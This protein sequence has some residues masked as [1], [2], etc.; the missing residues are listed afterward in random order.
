MFPIFSQSPRGAIAA[1]ALVGLCD[2]LLGAFT[3]VSA[4]M[5]I[6]YLHS[7]KSAPVNNHGGAAVVDVNGDGSPDLI[8][9]RYNLAPLLYI[10][11]GSGG[12]SEET[13]ARGLAPAVDAA[14]FGA[15]DFDND[16]DQ[17][18]FMSVHN[19]S[20]FYLFMNDGTGN[21]IED[22]SNRGA[23]LPVTEQAHKAHSIGLIDYDLD[24]YLDI[25]ISEWGVG[26]TGEQAFHS[27]L[28]RNRGLE[29]PGHFELRTEQAGLLQPLATTTQHGFS[30]GWADFDS[31]SWPDLALV[32]DYK[33][34]QMYW[35]DGDGTFTSSTEAS[36]VGFDENGMGV[37]VADYDNDGLLDFFV[38]SIYDEFSNEL[39]GTHAG[40]KLYRNMG[41]RNFQEVSVPAG[42]SRTGWGW[43]T[44]FFEYDND[45]DF[46]LIATNGMPIAEGS[47]RNTTPY[48]DAAQDPTT[49]FLNQDDGTFSDATHFSGISD[50]RYG[51]ALL[52]LDWDSD[53]D[54]DLV[55]V[56]SH[57]DPV[58]YESDASSG[59]NDWIRF[60][61][62]GTFSNRDAIGTS[63][64]VTEGGVTRHLYFN[65]SNA[66][67]GQREAALHFGLGDSDGVV[68]S[69]EIKWPTG[70]VQTLSDVPSNQTMH[71]RE[72]DDIPT[73]PIF[74]RQP[75]SVAS[76]S[77]GDPLELAVEAIGSPQPIYIWEKDGVALDGQNSSR[78]HLKR[79][80][81]FD[82]GVYR[83]KAVSA[84]GVTY[85][86]EV[87]VDL[88]ID[89]AT[90]SV[91]RW[92]NEFLLEAIRKDFPDPTKHSRNLYHV[93]A[94][95][96]DA[97][98]AYESDGWARAKP[99]FHRETVELIASES[100]R[101][102]AQREAISHAA[103]TVLR[104]RY[105]ESPGEERSQAG[106]VWLMEQFGFDPD[107]RS[108]EGPSPAAVG[109]RIGL[110]V[111]RINY[112]DGSN[113]LNQYADTS[114][115]ATVNEPLVLELSGTEMRDVNRWQ[116]LAF[117]FAIS[118]NG[119]PLGALVQTFL[120]VNWREVSSFAM[121]KPSHNTIAFDPGPPP[122][123]GGETH[124]AF[125]DA[126]IE[127]IRYSSFLDPND[128]TVID[129]SPGARLNN[130]LASNAGTGRNQNPVTGVAY[131]ANW[132]KRADYGRILAE[133]WADGP[134][135]ET[136]PGHWNSL[137]NEITDHPSF[138]RKYMGQGDELEPLEWDVRAYLALNGGMH[139]AAV[140][141]WTLKAQYDYSRPISMI[142]FLASLGQASDSQLPSFDEHGIKLV[143]GLVEVVTEESS[144]SGERHENFADNVGEIV[145][146]AWSGEPADA[147]TQAG[148]VDWI[149]A[150]DWFPYQRG[151]F[152]T[153]AFAAYVS[154]HST[155]SRAGAE[156]LTL[157]TGS[158]FFP[159]GLGEFH[160]PEGKFLEFEYG[161][162]HDVTLQWA[163]YYDAADQ[164]GVSRLYGGIHVA[165]DD[166]IGRTL[167]ARVGVEAFLRAHYQG[168]G[169]GRSAGILDKL[170][171]RTPLARFG[172]AVLARFDSKQGP[173][174]IKYTEDA[175]GNGQCLYIQLPDA[176]GVDDGVLLSGVGSLG[177]GR[178][179]ASLAEGE[180]FAVE[181]EV[182]A[183]E[184]VLTVGR[185]VRKSNDNL[186]T[187]ILLFQVL[188]SGVLKEIARNDYWKRGDTASQTEALI[189]RGADE[190]DLAEQDAALSAPLAEGRYRVVLKAMEGTGLVELSISGQGWEVAE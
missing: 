104:H 153:P 107:D 165:A 146:Y 3:D 16:G 71:L 10:N 182:A 14:A 17:D 23:D 151:S 62:E 51:K 27:A 88:Q 93:S 89:V 145:L 171:F 118:Q 20:R 76:Y 137:H 47:D 18:L 85:S 166:F 52:V 13:A 186:D 169:E 66:Y 4:T 99:M 46:D 21:F 94:A 106:F 164:A 38:T 97:F 78:L 19:G 144:A 31:D 39:N 121:K 67:I 175:A 115:Y 75:V 119:I 155:F 9:A 8:F 5:G 105:L 95:M 42:V 130:P 86:E 34:S 143:P 158:P 185:P 84:G 69:V 73:P 79:I 125:V 136:P 6:S 148:G 1:I 113:E 184:L 54:E 82:T 135:S 183:M 53:G 22:A 128:E 65:P 170:S 141:A 173:L 123:W 50:N 156:V 187:Q 60:T 15:A 70:L 116:P 140:A 32:A 109:N 163:T 111:L 188:E 87:A 139:D 101:L 112:E 150:A 58:F 181:F 108:T 77:F 11:D 29:L 129:I 159:D 131:E 168:S 33:K 161:P 81:P 25:Y 56:N 138:V 179:T 30:T 12:F 83:V 96:W 36:G 41:D 114:D 100:E 177:G 162:S 57:S 74:S 35:N 43:G 134:A 120:G 40:N 180:E 44:A 147:H 28:L 149:L 157:L 102:Q 90:H 55:V 49:L 172:E 68:D 7:Q 110:A 48:A 160:F 178:F 126:A 167:G 24:G 64:K 189:L 72:P 91:A 127:V 98:W 63:V 154:G 26:I 133:Y 142:R 174:P 59:S 152:V 103:F 122:Q 92:W 80:V 124:D 132:V 117:D 2:H 61:F 176:D 190:I 45:G 37:A